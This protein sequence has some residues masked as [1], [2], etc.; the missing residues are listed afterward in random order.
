MDVDFAGDVG[1]ARHVEAVMNLIG[2]LVRPKQIFQ[3]PDFVRRADIEGL[4]KYREA[5]AAGEL[6]RAQHHRPVRTHAD[7]SAGPEVR[8]RPP[9]ADNT[10]ETLPADPAARLKNPAS[11]RPGT[12]TGLRALLS[13]RRPVPKLLLHAAER[14]NRGPRRVEGLRVLDAERHLQRLAA[15]G[16]APA[17]GDV[18]LFGVRR[19]VIIH[20]GLAVLG[21]GVDDQRIA[22][23]MADRLAIPGRLRVGGRRHVEI[24]MPGL[25]VARR[26]SSPPP[27]ASE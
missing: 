9:R 1:A 12:R 5:R 27:S 20:E 6:R 17:L 8:P 18:Q 7:C 14:L 3:P 24:D 21:D 11:R 26:R 23:V 19:A 22:F 4:G 10:G 13:R 16:Q 2:D 25:L 15:V